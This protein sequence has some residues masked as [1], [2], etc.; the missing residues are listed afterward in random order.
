M[1]IY[2]LISGLPVSYTVSSQ[3]GS[4]SYSLTR[5]ETR[6]LIEWTIPAPSIRCD[7]HVPNFPSLNSATWTDGDEKF[8]RIMIDSPNTVLIKEDI[9]ADKK[10]TLNKNRDGYTPANDMPPL[11]TV[12]NNS[13]SLS[14]ASHTT[15]DIMETRC[16]DHDPNS[17]S[18][19]PATWTDGDEKF[20]HATIDSPNTVQTKDDGLADNKNTLDTTH[21]GYI[22]AD[23]TPPLTTVSNDS[24]SLSL[25]SHTTS[26][27]MVTRGDQIDGNEKFP[28]ATINKDNGLANKKDTLNTTHIGYISADET[29]PLATVSNNSFSLPST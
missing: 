6:S 27:I 11:A 5:T 1:E 2:Y 8:P 12:S 20:S 24:L 25:A 29:S 9:L 4:L 10:D 21:V 23:E 3:L 13:L 26:D 16:D 7:D 15:S 17:Y 28:R 18:Q 22:S 19:N 14:L